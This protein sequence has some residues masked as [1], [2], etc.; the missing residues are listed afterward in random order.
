MKPGDLRIVEANKLYTT[1]GLQWFAPA[2]DGVTLWIYAGQP[3]VLLWTETHYSK[4]RLPESR[5]VWFVLTPRGVAMTTE[6][7]LWVNTT[8]LESEAL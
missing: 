2:Q 8:S 4:D 5:T 3:V 7:S 1:S 6:S